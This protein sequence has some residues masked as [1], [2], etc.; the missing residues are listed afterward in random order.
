MTLNE[1]IVEEVYN[2]KYLGATF[3]TTGHGKDEISIR[4]DRALFAFCQLHN[5]LCL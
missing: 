5:H 1:E 3:T 2:F 4:I